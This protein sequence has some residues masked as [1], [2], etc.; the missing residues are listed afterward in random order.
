MMIRR[1]HESPKGTRS[2]RAAGV[3]LAILMSS[4][5]AKAETAETPAAD[6]VIPEGR[7][8]FAFSASIAPVLRVPDGAVI[9]AN[10]REASNNLVRP[11]MTSEEYRRIQWPDPYGHPLAGPIYIVGAQPGDKLAVTLLTLELGNWGWTDSSPESA[12]LGQEV[13]DSHVKTYTFSKDRKSATF[14]DGIT[15]PLRPFPGVMGV[16]PAT[17]EML[18][19]VPPRANGGNMDDPDIVEGT[20]VYFPVFVEGGLFSIGDPHAAQGHGEVSGTAIEAP[21][22]I[23][24]RVKVIKGGHTI[25]EPQYETDDLYAVTAFAATLD[26][27]ARKATRYMIAWLMDV[28]GMQRH[29]ANML[30]SVAANLKI[31]EVV[32][33]NVLVTMHMPRSVFGKN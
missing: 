23:V 24:Y 12:F 9:E 7:E 6:F 3:A 16:A 1:W 32:D 14:T 15:V 30:S 18:S 13:G 22:R 11:G 5:C 19:T 29:E 21:M 17:S 8:H 10:T 20:T 25:A 31:A 27:A 26:E 2:S 4:A 33:G 28:H